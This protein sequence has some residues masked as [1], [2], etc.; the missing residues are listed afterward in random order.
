MEGIPSSFCVSAS[1]SVTEFMLSE[2][3]DMP[4]VLAE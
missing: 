4:P 3:K 2:R 1:D